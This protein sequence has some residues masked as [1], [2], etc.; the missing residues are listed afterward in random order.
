MSKFTIVDHA[1]VFHD[2]AESL[3]RD[4]LFL[5]LCSMDYCCSDGL[6]DLLKS[7]IEEDLQFI[8]R[9]M[10][11]NAMEKA[12]APSALTKS[13]NQMCNILMK[14]CRS[15]TG[16]IISMFCILINRVTYGLGCFCSNHSDQDVTSLYKSWKNLIQTQDIGVSLL[17]LQIQE[18][19]SCANIVKAIV[20]IKMEVSFTL[21]EA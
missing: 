7:L 20:K 3:T 2:D 19:K 8:T 10:V 9:G 1:L 11:Y 21:Q 15:L 18:F 13:L 5:A 12:R 6:I 17:L 16:A 4:Q 14:K